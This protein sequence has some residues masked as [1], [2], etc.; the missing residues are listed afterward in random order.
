VSEKQAIEATRRQMRELVDGT[1]EVKL[2]VEPRFKADF[3]RLFANIDMPV[4]IAPLHLGPSAMPSAA[5]DEAIVTAAREAVKGGEL[6]KLAAILCADEEFQ[7][8]IENDAHVHMDDRPTETEGIDAED[9]AAIIV[10]N[11]CDIQS[12][13]ELDHNELAADIFHER[14]RKPYNEHMNRK[15]PRGRK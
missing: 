10:R 11:L 8:W 3:H 12:R 6:C 15:Y 9:R 1:L 2:H 4:A 5:T 7:R 14:I 13:R